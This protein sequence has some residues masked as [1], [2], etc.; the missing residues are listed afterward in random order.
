LRLPRNLSGTELVKALA[1][2]G[3]QVS[4][5]RGSHIRDVQEINPSGM[6]GERLRLL[7]DRASARVA[8]TTRD[9]VRL[10]LFGSP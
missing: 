1:S 3:Y 2:L 7:C 9:I 5:Q 8:R 6:W 10:F 4:H